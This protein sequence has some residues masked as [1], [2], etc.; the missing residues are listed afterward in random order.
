MNEILKNALESLSAR[1]NLATG[2]IHPLDMDSA[3]EMFKILHKNGIDL[4]AS[5]IELWANNNGWQAKYARE[6][7]DLGQKIGD[8]GRVQIRNK[9]CW[10]TNPYSAWKQEN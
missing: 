6:L 9:N 3:K 8:G 5:E 7:G 10:G 4:D 2:L 1:V